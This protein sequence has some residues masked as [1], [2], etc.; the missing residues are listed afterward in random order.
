MNQATVLIVDDEP[1]VIRV[2]RLALERAGYRVQG[3]A[4]GQA[5]LE[6]M[7]ACRPHLLVCDLQMPRMGGR[8][9]CEAVRAR[10]PDETIPIILMSSM[11]ALSERAWA[12]SLSDVEFLEKPLSPRQL[13][14]RAAARIPADPEVPA[15]TPVP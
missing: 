14:A 13:V 5:A 10:Y 3:A 4:D 8:A 12:Q 2:L 6:A 1:H 15:C 7:Q 9:L 11:T